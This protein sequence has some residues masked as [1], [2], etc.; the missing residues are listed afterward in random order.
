M[1][2]FRMIESNSVPHRLLETHMRPD[3]LNCNNTTI[4]KIL[5]I[6]PTKNRAHVR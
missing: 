6:P 4:I 5:A 2:F 1:I 3:K